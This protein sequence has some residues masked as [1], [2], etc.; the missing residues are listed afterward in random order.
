MVVE[1]R[2]IWYFNRR[3]CDGLGAAGGS[4]IR[5]SEGAISVPWLPHMAIQAPLLLTHHGHGQDSRAETLKK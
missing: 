2:F 4:A 1:V 3:I 5:W